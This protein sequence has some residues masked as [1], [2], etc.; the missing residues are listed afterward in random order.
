MAPPLLHDSD[1]EASTK[2]RALGQRSDDGFDRIVIT[3]F[4]P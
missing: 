4:D 2:N 1:R 3:L